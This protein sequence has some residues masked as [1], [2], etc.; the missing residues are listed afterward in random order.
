MATS[1]IRVRPWVY[2][3]LFLLP[4]VGFLLRGGVMGAV[5]YL[6]LAVAAG[7]VLLAGWGISH[8]WRRGRFRALNGLRA[9]VLALLVLAGLGLW[10]YGGVAVYRFTADRAELPVPDRYVAVIVVDG[11]SLLQ[12]RALLYQGLDDKTQYDRAVGDAFPNI[13]QYFLTGGAFTAC[14]VSTWPSSSIPAHTG[15]VTGCYPRTTGVMGQRQFNTKTRRYTSYIGLGILAHRVILERGVKTIGEWF[16]H[17]RSLDVV[18][19][20]NR[21]CSLYVPAP[22]SD[23]LA[24]RRLAQVLDLAALFG[25]TEIPRIA[26]ITLPD[27]D[28]LTHNSFVSDEKSID[29]YLQTDRTV[30]EIF[31]LYKRKGIFEQTLFVLCADHGMGEVRNHVTLDNLMHDM[32]FDTFQSFKWTAVP[33]WGSFEANAWLGTRGRFDRIYNCLPLWGGNSDALLYVKGRQGNRASWDIPVTDE[34]LRRYAVGGTEIDV[35]R[36]LLDYSPGIGLVFTHPEQDTFNVYGQ[37][38]QGQIRERVEQG[39]REF[40]YRVVSGKDP[41]EYAEHPATAPFVKS[42]AW[43]DDQAWLRLT[44]LAHY[45]DAI[46]R[47]AFSF[48]H[49]NAASMHIVAADDWD[50]APYY[51]AKRVL[52][53][54]HGSLNAPQSLVPIMFHGPGIKRGELA[55]GRTVDIL[56][57]ILAYFGQEN[58]GLDGRPLPVFADEAK[59]ARLTAGAGCSAGPLAGGYGLEAP[60]ASYDRR[61]VRMRGGTRDVIVPS[62]RA[63]VPALRAQPN[64]TTE[65]AGWQAPHLLLRIVYAGERRADG[66]LRYNTATRTFE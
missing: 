33:A 23:A 4:T 13:A 28:H 54:S 32:R 55:Y 47:I 18:Q 30:G 12:A 57:T 20:A 39:R 44:Y 25:K 35:I 58:A 16:P 50:F 34:M 15:I 6:A 5:L 62:L 65:Y 49:P 10:L 61:I 48:G 38:G 9:A 24:V 59:N 41:L 36:R 2:P 29:L 22:P 42:G 8:L 52:V 40:S 7:V 45:P 63:A 56:P 11:A 46:R 14:G 3:A 21:G 51:V 17:T 60:Y 37:A 64:I 1:R 53:G 31:D 27:I 26:V 43:L 66:L 19:V